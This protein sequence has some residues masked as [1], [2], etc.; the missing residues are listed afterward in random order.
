M[1]QPHPAG[2]I[3]YD[4]SCGFCRRWIPFWEKTLSKRG[5]AIAPL[6]SVWVQRKLNLPAGELMQDLRLLLPNNTQVQGAEVYRYVMRRIW[7]AYPL[8][9]FSIA[10]LTARVF[11]WGYRTFATNRYHFSRICRLPPTSSADQAT[12]SMGHPKKRQVGNH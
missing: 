3:L 10:P 6:Q 4:D 11:D 7:W 12:E 1:S 8:Y 9:L 5:F 2:W